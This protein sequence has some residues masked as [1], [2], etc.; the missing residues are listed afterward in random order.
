[1]NDGQLII[2]ISAGKT[3]SAA[4]TAPPLNTKRNCQ[5]IVHNF[6]LPK[7]IPNEYGHLQGKSITTIQARLKLLNYFSDVLH[8]VW[9]FLP[10]CSTKVRMKIKTKRERE[11]NS[12][13]VF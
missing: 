7:T 13:N 2:Q 10:L 4:W 9:R 3:H 8:N 6:G 5:G 1:M 11:L 12:N